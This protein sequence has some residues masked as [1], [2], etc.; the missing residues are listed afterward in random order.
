MLFRS[1]GRVAEGI[2]LVAKEY[3]RKSAQIAN[4]ATKL[5]LSKADV[6]Q[7]FNIVESSLSCASKKLCAAQRLVTSE[8]LLTYADKIGIKGTAVIEEIKD[9]SSSAKNIGFKTGEEIKGHLGVIERWSTNF[10]TTRIEDAA[11][12]NR[13]YPEPP[14]LAGS[15]VVEF[16]TTAAES[17]VRVHGSNNVARPWIMRQSDIEGLTASEIA[18]KFNIPEVPSQL[19]RVDIPSG[20]KIRTGIVGPNAFGNSK[21]AIQYEIRMPDNAR[22]PESWFQPIRNF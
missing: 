10:K 15:K 2:S 16:E 9:L 6:Q 19:S 1:V 5:L 4:K 17:F 20:V 8:T 3:A 18:A 7:V 11:V 12:I 13:G 21:G 14:Y 22:I